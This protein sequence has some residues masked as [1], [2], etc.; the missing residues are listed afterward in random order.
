MR[1][2][3]RE[4]V[5]NVNLAAGIAAG[6]LGGLAGAWAM[7]RYHTAAGRLLRQRLPEQESQ[8]GRESQGQEIGSAAL[9][10]MQDG[11]RLRTAQEIAHE[12]LGMVSP[13]AEELQ[14]AIPATEKAASA[15]ATGI[16]RRDLEP[17]QRRKAGAMT[18][19]AFGAAVGGFYGAIA[20]VSPMVH[21]GS[22]IP[23][24]IAVWVA[25]DEV[26]VPALGLSK[27]P[28][29]YPPSTHMNALF[30]HIV[31]G[32]ALEWVRRVVRAVL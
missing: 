31:F 26:A 16:L 19:Y 17:Q 12:R 32:I 23:Y 11:S 21:T 25:A 18:H 14:Q 20:E 9:A 29:A 24:G 2:I 1:V 28:V 5:D 6:V 4:D 15:V 8:G 7:N 22:G 10:G 3:W 27:K 13:P 30:S